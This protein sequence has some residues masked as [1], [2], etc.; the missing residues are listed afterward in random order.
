[1]PSLSTLVTQGP[2]YFMQQ[3]VRQ[4][5]PVIWL[6]MRNWREEILFQRR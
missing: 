6:M 3:F 1:M 4:L 5:V 2:V